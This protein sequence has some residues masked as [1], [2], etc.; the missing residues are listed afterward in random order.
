[1][2]L[3]PILAAAVS[4]PVA[5]LPEQVAQAQASVRVVRMTRISFAS[6]RSPWLKDAPMVHRRGG[7]DAGL[8]L[9]EFE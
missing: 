9:I 1:M 2:L 6:A 8:S 7:Q 3:L 4:I 5:P